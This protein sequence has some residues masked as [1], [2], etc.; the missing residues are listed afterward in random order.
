MRMTNSMRNL[1]AI[2]GVRQPWCPLSS[3][4]F[5][6]NFIFSSTAS[7]CRRPRT[8][9]RT[10]FWDPACLLGSELWEASSQ[11]LLATDRSEPSPGPGHVPLA[12]SHPN[13]PG[14]SL[15][16]GSWPHQGPNSY[17]EESASVCPVGRYA[18]K[19]RVSLEPEAS[20]SSGAVPLLH[21]TIRS[22]SYT[23]CC[24]N[25]SAPKLCH[26]PTTKG[27]EKV[28]KPLQNQ[29]FWGRSLSLWAAAGRGFPIRGLPQHKV[30]S[31]GTTSRRG[32]QDRED[33]SSACGW[34]LPTL[35]RI[36]TTMYGREGDQKQK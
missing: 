9:H 35:L 16:T 2:G 31:L 12:G 6:V 25:K 8:L 14:S 11:T 28:Y 22:H 7:V 17:Q 36:P 32:M 5:S 26:G 21:M 29:L 33:P 4:H 24:H 20:K 27:L 30:C 19:C 3:L 15:P 23:S 1:L 10:R 18:N 13:S 34:T